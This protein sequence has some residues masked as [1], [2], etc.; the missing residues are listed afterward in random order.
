MCKCAVV[1]ES[2]HRAKGYRLDWRCQPGCGGRC[3]LRIPLSHFNGD[4]IAAAKVAELMRI[5]IEASSDC[6]RKQEFQDVLRDRIEEWRTGAEKKNID[7]RK[8]LHRVKRTKYA[9]IKEGIKP[10][11]A[12]PL[13][14]WKNGQWKSTLYA[15]LIE[16]GR[17]VVVQC[18]RNTND[19]AEVVECRHYGTLTDLVRE[20]HSDLSTDEEE[21]YEVFSRQYAQRQCSQGFV[22]F[23]LQMLT[24]C[25]ES[26]HGVM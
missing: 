19:V 11:D 5:Y 7:T 22:A 18:G 21:C 4:A 9:L 8:V 1:L 12:R 6:S 13:K 23:K 2:E 15:Q 17:N 26:E 20:L 25:P 3:R 24:A 10:W 16:C 14:V